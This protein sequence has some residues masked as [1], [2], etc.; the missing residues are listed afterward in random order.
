[1]GWDVVDMFTILQSGTSQPL[2]VHLLK[3]EKPNTD[4]ILIFNVII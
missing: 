2:V 4:I 1:M 3:E